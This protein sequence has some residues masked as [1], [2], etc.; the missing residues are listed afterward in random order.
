VPVLLSNQHGT[1]SFQL[2]LSPIPGMIQLRKARSKRRDELFC[3][4][5]RYVFFSPFKQDVNRL[6]QA[7]CRVTIP[8]GLQEKDRYGTEG[9]G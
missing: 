9:H 5:F 1:A 4:L 7:G 8:E 3:L 2:M 6:Q